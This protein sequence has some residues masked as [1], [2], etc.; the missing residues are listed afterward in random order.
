M[1]FIV[2]RV[3]TYVADGCMHLMFPISD[4]HVT[5]TLHILFD[6]SDFP[7]ELKFQSPRAVTVSRAVE[8]GDTVVVACSSSPSNPPAAI[9]YE[10]CS[11][12][13]LFADLVTKCGIITIKHCS[14]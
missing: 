11:L 14:T 5:S 13:R 12:S 7:K 9:R 4:F 8:Y 3:P 6:F 1:S 2:F 10:N